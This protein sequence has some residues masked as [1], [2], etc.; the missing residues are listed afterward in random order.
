MNWNVE[1]ITIADA[2]IELRTANLRVVNKTYFVI[3]DN[4]EW[5][6]IVHDWLRT[7]I[8]VAQ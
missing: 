1:P 3:S 5:I 4:A 2:R 8:A 7:Y 6:V